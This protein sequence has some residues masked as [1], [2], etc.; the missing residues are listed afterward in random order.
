MAEK[1]AVKGSMS[2][3]VEMTLGSGEEGARVEHV[4]HHEKTSKKFTQLPRFLE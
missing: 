2:Q 3:I 1:G 4:K